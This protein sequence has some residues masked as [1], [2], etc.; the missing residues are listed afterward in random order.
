MILWSA[1]SVPIVMSVPQ[2]SLSMDPTIPTMLRCPCA[3]ASSW[4]I[5]PVST[6]SLI[7]SCHSSRNLLAPVR[8]PSPPMATRLVIPRVTRLQAAFNRPSR[9]RKSV[10][11]KG[12]RRLEVRGL[13]S[14]TCL[15]APFNVHNILLGYDPRALEWR[16]LAP[17]HW[18][19]P[20]RL[21]KGFLAGANEPKQ[22]R[23]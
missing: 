19:L 5:F 10:H 16:Q 4:L 3:S 7:N 18:P 17:C 1:E 20:E 8:V 15:L 9:S 12:K 2:K 13:L 22:G 23:R 14:T 11:L 21:M 6:S